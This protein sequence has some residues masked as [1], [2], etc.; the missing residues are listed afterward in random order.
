MRLSSSPRF[1]GADE[2]LLPP[3]RGFVLPAVV[4]ELQ[5][6][7]FGR[8]FQIEPARRAGNP[9]L[10]G[11]DDVVGHHRQRVQQRFQPAVVF[12]PGELE[13]V[14][15]RRHEQ[16]TSSEVVHP[17]LDVLDRLV[18]DA[19]L[20]AL[21]LLVPVEIE[22]DDEIVLVEV[23]VLVQLALRGVGHDFLGGVEP[24]RE[25]RQQPFRRHVLDDLAGDATFRLEVDAHLGPLFTH[26]AHE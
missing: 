14:Q 25:S 20:V 10:A 15:G 24:I 2:E 21:V 4:F 16:E 6:V 17:R 7:G 5:E 3:G 8:R 13:R 22:C 9:L 18:G 19:E 1:V 23:V 26:F 11:D 12:G